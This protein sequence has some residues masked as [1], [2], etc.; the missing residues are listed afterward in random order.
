MTFR[1]KTTCEEILAA[2]ESRGVCLCLDTGHLEGVG[3]LWPQ[4]GGSVNPTSP[5]ILIN[6]LRPSSFRCA[7]AL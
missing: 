1:E 4:I 3:I 6:R 7:I 5:S 2:I